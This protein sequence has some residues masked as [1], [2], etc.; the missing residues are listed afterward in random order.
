MKGYAYKKKATGT[1]A[2]AAKEPNLE[3]APLSAMV[4]TA[5]EVGEVVAGARVVGAT[6]LTPDG[7]EAAMVVS[8][9]ET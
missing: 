5:G 1:M 8:E 2:K 3:A 9:T 6:G 4:E 7:V